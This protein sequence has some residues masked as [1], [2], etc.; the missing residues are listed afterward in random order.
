MRGNLPRP[1][2]PDTIAAS[3]DVSEVRVSPAAP[4]SQEGSSL[5]LTC[6]A[7]S[8]QDLEFQWLREKV[9]RWAQVSGARGCGMGGPRSDL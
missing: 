9:P 8:N 5:T 3:P 1:V 7:E 2:L 4:E 6:E